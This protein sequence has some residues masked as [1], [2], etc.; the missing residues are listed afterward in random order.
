MVAHDNEYL[1]DFLIKPLLIRV[2]IQQ[3]DNYFLHSIP[4]VLVDCL[5]IVAVADKTVDTD[6]VDN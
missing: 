4:Q 1:Q 3:L 2:D 6:K 5:A